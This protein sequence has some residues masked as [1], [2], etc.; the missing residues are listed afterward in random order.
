MGWGGVERGKGGRWFW[1]GGGGG[2]VRRLSFGLF[3]YAYVSRYGYFEPHGELAIMI[4]VMPSST[5]KKKKK[6][7]ERE[8]RRERLSLSLSLSQFH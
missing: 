3:L 4:E 8:R 7:R 1:V 5:K 6:K 2:D